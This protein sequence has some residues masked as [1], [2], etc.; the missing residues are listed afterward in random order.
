MDNPPKLHNELKQRGLDLEIDST[1]KVW[2]KYRFF[3]NDAMKKCFDRFCGQFEDEFLVDEDKLP[4]SP[5]L[6]L[7]LRK[8]GENYELVEQRAAFVAELLKDW[9]VG[10]F[11]REDI[12][13]NTLIKFTFERFLFSAEHY[14]AALVEMF[15]DV[16]TSPVMY[17]VITVRKQL[18]S[19]ESDQ[20][21]AAESMFQCVSSFFSIDANDT[22]AVRTKFMYVLQCCQPQI[23]RDIFSSVNHI[24]PLTLQSLAALRTKFDL[25]CESLSKDE[26]NYWWTVES[27]PA[28][29]Y[30]LLNSCRY[31][32]ETILK[33]L[34]DEKNEFVNSSY[35]I[36]NDEW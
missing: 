12:P 33:E 36:C 30:S 31:D 5:N 10:N 15:L 11:Y 24:V 2:L 9:K 8:C 18:E 1:K 35:E 3:P 19:L 32:A 28:D 27:Q 34:T 7:R 26:R 29:Y 23:Y 25:D 6:Y 22:I 14:D 21:E 4:L 16:V 20:L 13:Q 17:E